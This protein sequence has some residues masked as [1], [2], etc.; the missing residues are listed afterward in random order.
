MPHLCGGSV[1]A[2]AE[3]KLFAHVKHIDSIA[4]A[5]SNEVFAIALF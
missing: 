5:A 1:P 2:V 4:T 3:L